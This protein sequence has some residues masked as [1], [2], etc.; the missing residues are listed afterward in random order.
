[1]QLSWAHLAPCLYN[2]T[3]PSG[4]PPKLAPTAVSFHPPLHLRHLLLPLS[5]F[6]NQQSKQSRIKVLPLSRHNNARPDPDKVQEGVHGAAPAEPARDRTG[7]QV[8]GPPRAPRRRTPLLRRGHGAGVVVV[9]APGGGG[10]WLFGQACG[11]AAQRGAPAPH[12]GRR[13]L[14][15]GGGGGG[16]ELQEGGAVQA[17]SEEVAP[18]GAERLPEEVVGERRRWWRHGGQ[19][20]GEGA[21]AGAQDARAGR[22]EAARLLPAQRDA[23]LRCVPQDAGGAHAMP[24]QRI[25][26]QARLSAADLIS[27]YMFF[28]RILFLV[29]CITSF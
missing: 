24:V 7:V 6:K 20:D 21:D 9:C 8:H 4:P 15:D 27:G 12:H 18:G 13:R 22:G 1:M 25:P 14:R 16:G 17:D 3:N 19:E 23:G 29:P 28:I 5:S 10:A 2:H 11:G 26:I